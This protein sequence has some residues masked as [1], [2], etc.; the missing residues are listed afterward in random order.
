M[1]PGARLQESIDILDG[2]LADGQPA[3]RFLDHWFRRRR[4]AG[5]KDRRAI[6]ERVYA[7]LRAYGAL[8]WW[9]GEA[10]PVRMLAL[11]ERILADAAT[12]DELTMLCDGGPHRPA[13]LSAAER[14]AL[15]GLEGK[16]LFVEELPLDSRFNLTPW[17]AD[18]ARAGFGADTAAELAALSGRAPA[19]L[20][21]NTLVTVRETVQEVLAAAGI[22]ADPTPFSPA[23]LRLAD[24][25]PIRGSAPFRDGWI[26]FQDEGSQLAALLCCARPGMDVLDLCAGGG[27]K[28]LALAAAMENRGSLTLCDSDPGR[29][30]PATRR[31]RRAG[32]RIAECRTV[33]AEGDP[34]LAGQGGRFDIVLVDAPCTGSGAWRRNPE[35]PIRLTESRFEE[36]RAAQAA[37]LAEA[38]PLVKPG[39][40]LVYVT[41]SVLEAENSAAVTRFLDAG[42]EFDIFPVA[43][44]WQDVIGGDCPAGD[45]F[46]QLTPFRHQTDG[47]FV[48]VLTRRTADC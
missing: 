41:C 18:L 35:A 4:F 17:F 1:T 6:R 9:C 22:L 13:P 19:D 10:A 30:K 31:L 32:V 37:L 21:V 36:L 38:A 44:I 23:G 7:V 43:R 5:S 3:D 48:A 29:L 34:W 27:G 45:R 39:G 26:E 47:F 2:L 40:R 46:L 20:R 8:R 42:A 16:Q 15:A 11:S 12:V 25:A 33:E 28:S 14:E 24:Q